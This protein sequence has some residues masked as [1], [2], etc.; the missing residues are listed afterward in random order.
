MENTD[1]L[2]QSISPIYWKRSDPAP[3]IEMQSF[4]KKLRHFYRTGEQVDAPKKAFS[5]ALIGLLDHSTSAY[6]FTLGDAAE[7]VTIVLE[8]KAPFQ[9]LD[10]LLTKHHEENRKL[11]KV[12]LASLIE[13]LSKLLHINDKNTDI[14]TLKGDYDFASELIAFDK[15]VDMVPHTATEKLSTARSTRLMAVVASLKEGLA[16]FNKHEAVVVF[17]KYFKAVIEG[18]SLFKKALLI[19]AEHDAFEHIQAVFNR[20]VQAFTRLMRAYRIAQLE[21]EGAYQE[22]I[23]DDY[24][25]HFS[26]Y[27][28]LADE[29]NLFHPVILVVN[30]SRVFEHLTSFS[31][32]MSSNQPIKV[33]VLN[34]E[35]ITTP[36]DQLSWEDASHQFRQE[37]AA[38]AIAHRNV[39]TFQSSMA[40]PAIVYNGMPNF[41]KST[42]PGICHLSI[43]KDDISNT[44]SPALLANAANAGRYFPRIIY[45]PAKYSEWGRRFDLV[46]NIQ[47]EEKWPNLTL[48]VNSDESKEIIMDVAFTYADYKAIFPEKASELMWIPVAFYSDYLIPLN[49]YLQLEGENLYGKIPYIYLLDE[50]RKLHR[51]AVPNVWVV[52]CQER[53][54]FWCFLQELGGLNSY[55]S[56]VALQQKDDEIIRLLAEHKSKMDA[57]RQ[58]I[59]ATAQEEAIA[60]A[61]ERLVLALLSDED[62][63]LDANS[64]VNTSH[65]DPSD[66]LRKTLNIDSD[67]HTDK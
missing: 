31:R 29:L 1:K 21:I 25:E 30:Q 62:L 49:H 38:L 17:E 20:E 42:A 16:L 24:F 66:T 59:V 14:E 9:L 22:A 60:I 54:D 5:S 39:Y 11:F 65:E 7:K 46:D 40:D 19:E 51:A 63:L 23:H 32:L 28:L 10:V 52:S 64:S 12:Q 3:E 56:K 57:E 6:P 33:V 13:G 47:A 27:R 2:R 48:K 26:W 36:S 37:I 4:W 45:D 35:L 18:A 50:E 41:L 44:M 55:H 61:A 53:L 15:M 58:Q 34:H 8:E 43:P 67:K